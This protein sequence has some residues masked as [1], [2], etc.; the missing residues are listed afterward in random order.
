MP[1]FLKLLGLF[2]TADMLSAL[3]YYLPN[4]RNGI[5]IAIIFLFFILTRRRLEYG[6]AFIF[7]EIFVGSKG[8]L[9]SFALGETLISIRV[10]LF[11]V[12]FSV[13]FSKLLFKFYFDTPV[14]RS[15]NDNDEWRISWL[16]I[17]LFFAAIF[18]GIV[19]GLLRGHDLGLVFLDANGYFFSFLIF[20]VLY[21]IRNAES[22][23]YLRT[24]LPLILFAGT[25]WLAA[26]T[27]IL[28]VLFIRGQDTIFLG[29]IYSWIRN[30]VGE[31][32]PA[33]GSLYRV[34]IQSQ[35]FIV[36]A[37]LIFL[38]RKESRL[39]TTLLGAVYLA[40]IIVSL[41]R[42]FWLGAT[43]AYGLGLVAYGFKKEWNNIKEFFIKGLLSAVGA[44]IILSIIYLPA[45][46]GF[47]ERFKNVIGEPA[48]SSRLAQFKPLALEI[49]KSP[50]L[51]YGFGKTVTYKTSD[52]R[53][54]KSNPTGVYTTYAFELGYL[55]ILLEVGLLGLL[56]YLFLIYKIWNKTQV[57][58]L[59]L[60][61]IALL[62]IN[63]FSPYLNHPLGIGLLLL[64]MCWNQESTVPTISG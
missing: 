7:A 18:F 38:T 32:T 14:Y 44:I 17:I 11:I 27:L 13:F 49:I 48:A 33:G 41:S 64:A 45:L 59:R 8:Y 24:K 62:V 1:K 16:T 4:L 60:G 34:F 19:N 30:T 56:I 39:A 31:I 35:L 52:P 20:P 2:I 57:L 37:Y 47:G 28:F 25:A 5:F 26:K 9:F 54:L 53:I 61:L 29:Q 42:S 10:A 21:L 55:D 6:L 36:L 51:G 40:A 46:R 12:F 22:R 58:G 43:S 3:A 15:K 50:I 23:L 63:I